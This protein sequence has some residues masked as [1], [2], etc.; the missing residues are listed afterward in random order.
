MTSSLDDDELSAR[1]FAVD[2]YKVCVETLHTNL[3]ACVREIRKR[4]GDAAT[5]LDRIQVKRVELSRAE[6]SVSTTIGLHHLECF[7]DPRQS[8][9]TIEETVDELMQEWMYAFGVAKTRQLFAN[10]AYA[11]EETPHG[12]TRIETI[13]CQRCL[14]LH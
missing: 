11:L 2:E 7:G 13:L 1:E 6:R 8:R 4:F 9:Y 5:L 3:S 12:G 10:A 14:A